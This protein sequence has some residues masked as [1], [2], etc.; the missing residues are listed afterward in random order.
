MY[1]VRIGCPKEADIIRNASESEL[2]VHPFG[3]LKRLKDGSLLSFRQ[4]RYAPHVHV[5]SSVMN[6][7]VFSSPEPFMIKTFCCPSL[8]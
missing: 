3:M 7:E 2:S 1:E 6:H 8:S 4:S 5:F